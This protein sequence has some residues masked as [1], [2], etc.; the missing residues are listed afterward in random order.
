MGKGE[1]G[2]ESDLDAFKEAVEKQGKQYLES[3]M[4]GDIDTWID[5]WDEDGVQMPSNAP[6]RVGKQSIYEGN[7]RSFELGIK[8][9]TVNS[10]WNLKLIH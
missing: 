4:V 1:W 9:F 6:A 8:D 3:V 7:R 10:G 5:C 2:S